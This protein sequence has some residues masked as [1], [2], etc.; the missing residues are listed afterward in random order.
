MPGCFR[1]KA[2]WLESRGQGYFWTH[3]LRETCKCRKARPDRRPMAITSFG[4][5]FWEQTH[6]FLFVTAPLFRARKAIVFLPS[7]ACLRRRSHHREQHKAAIKISVL[8]GRWPLFWVGN[9]GFEFAKF[10][11]MYAHQ[12][13][14]EHHA[15]L[16]TCNMTGVSNAHL[17][18][19]SSNINLPNLSSSPSS[20]N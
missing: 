17:H 19:C 18:M 7:A 4:R 14:P 12:H 5:A 15:R 10:I 11:R 9:G 1:T 3:V 20:H 6:R 16:S 2:A 13:P 8:F